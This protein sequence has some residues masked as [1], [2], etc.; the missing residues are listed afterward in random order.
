MLSSK[1]N[2]SNKYQ[3]PLSPVVATIFMESFESIALENLHLKPEIWLR[4]VETVLSPFGLTVES[5]LDH[6]NSQLPDIKFTMEVKKYAVVPYFDDPTVVQVI[7]ST[8]NPRTLIDIYMPI[9]TIIWR[10][11]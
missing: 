1:V 7:Q 2:S 10:K 9:P 3:E 11:S 5:F 6:L 4:Y 8:K